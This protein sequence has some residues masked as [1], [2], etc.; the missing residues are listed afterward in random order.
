M[1]DSRERRVIRREISNQRHIARSTVEIVIVSCDI[2]VHYI[3]IDWRVRETRSHQSLEPAA[4]RVTSRNSSKTSPRKHQ[5][6][7][8]IRSAPAAYPF[9][10]SLS[11]GPRHPLALPLFTLRA[12]IT[13][14]T[15]SLFAPSPFPVPNYSAPKRRCRH[16]GFLPLR[17]Q[18]LYNAASSEPPTGFASCASGAAAVIAMVAAAAA[19]AHRRC[20]VSSTICNRSSSP[21][22]WFNIQ[23]ASLVQCVTQRHRCGQRQSHVRERMHR[24]PVCTRARVVPLSLP[25]AASI[26]FSALFP[27][28]PSNTTSSRSPSPH[29]SPLFSLHGY[30]IVPYVSS[31]ISLSLFVPLSVLHPPPRSLPIDLSPSLLRASRSLADNCGIF[32]SLFPLYFSYVLP[33][34][35]LRPF[36]PP[37][38]IYT[39]RIAYA[40]KRGAN[41]YVVH[42][43]RETTYWCLP[44][45]HPLF[46]P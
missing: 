23:Y 2:R 22:Y 35:L 16:R 18:Y 9:R 13:L 8:P 39:A 15:G 33:P 12:R 24:A 14:S 42:V 7:S 19:A 31:P 17:A 29:L 4:F 10:L 27:Y 3:Q 32:F 37:R 30:L 26:P 28:S 43:R 40:C 5:V 41:V 21:V 44:S 25:S 36:P 6:I 38:V 45:S 46:P 1:P 20:Q 34:S 11:H